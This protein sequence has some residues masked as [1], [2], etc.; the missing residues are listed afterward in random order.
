MSSSLLLVLGRFSYLGCSDIE[1]LQNLAH[2]TGLT[3][4]ALEESGVV[5]S[6]SKKYL[7]ER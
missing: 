6:H 3:E 2:K 7:G 5:M 4:K 1:F